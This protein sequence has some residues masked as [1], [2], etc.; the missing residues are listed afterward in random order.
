MT[1]TILTLDFE[2]SDQHGRYL[3]AFAAAVFEYPSGKCVRSL[4]VRRVCD[5]F[6]YDTRTKAF[7]NDNTEALVYMMSVVPD[8]MF[9]SKLASFVDQ[10]H[11]DFPNVQIV[12][13]NP[14][15]DISLVNMIL[16]VQLQARIE[17]RYATHNG[18]QVPDR[19]MGRFTKVIDTSTYRKTVGMFVTLEEAPSPT[20]P[21]ELLNAGA[22]PHTP[23]YDCHVIANDYFDTIRQARRFGQLNKF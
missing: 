13:D 6:Q 9:A 14:A 7:W 15:F 17:F 4:E 20:F 5:M 8:V 18:T 1:L 23:L 19:S 22:C 12:S 10:V 16:Q 11:R 2:T 3:M 21:Q